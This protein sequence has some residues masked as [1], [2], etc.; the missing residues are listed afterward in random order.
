MKVILAHE[1]ACQITLVSSLA[2]AALMLT[3]P[4]KH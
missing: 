2:L 1:L 4:V 3:L